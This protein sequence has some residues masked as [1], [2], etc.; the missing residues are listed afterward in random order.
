[1]FDRLFSHLIGTFTTILNSISVIVLVFLSIAVLLVVYK[2]YRQSIFLE[3]PQSNNE[4]VKFYEGG[5]RLYLSEKEA[6]KAFLDYSK[7]AAEY[8]FFH[9]K[10]IARQNRL[11]KKLERKK[12]Y[13]Y[14]ESFKLK[15]DI[16]LSEYKY[17]HVGFDPFFLEN[18]YSQDISYG[19][20]A[21][22]YDDEDYEYDDQGNPI[23]VI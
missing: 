17:E 16:K 3:N 6:A 14:L 11:D 9:G 13:Y 12:A 23:Q 5:Q 21:Y 18:F 10:D 20:Y 2:K 15:K 8:E 19:D 1:M 7:L 22:G 4:F